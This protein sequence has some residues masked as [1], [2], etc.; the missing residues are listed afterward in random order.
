[1]LYGSTIATE[2]KDLDYCWDFARILS[3]EDKAGKRSVVL[4]QTV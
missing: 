2:I 1:M 3:R 4:L